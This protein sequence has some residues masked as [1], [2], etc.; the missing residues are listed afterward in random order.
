MNI[1]RLNHLLLTGLTGLGFCAGLSG[2]GQDTSLLATVPILLGGAGIAGL[3]Y[4]V[5]EQADIEL[6]VREGMPLIVLG[7]V[8]ALHFQLRLPEG[9]PLRQ[10]VRVTASP[11]GI[12]EVLDPVFYTDETIAGLTPTEEEERVQRYHNV[13]IPRLKGISVGQAQIRIE[14][15]GTVRTQTVQVVVPDVSKANEVKP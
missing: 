2:C 13:R 9:T 1:S 15:L 8:K 12:V 14:A 3:G 5:G 10:E 7:Q 11:P 6:P 4:L